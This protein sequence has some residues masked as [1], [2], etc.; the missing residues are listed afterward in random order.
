MKKILEAIGL[1]KLVKWLRRK[2]EKP[3]MPPPED[4]RS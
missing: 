1:A 2:D 3:Q 4:V